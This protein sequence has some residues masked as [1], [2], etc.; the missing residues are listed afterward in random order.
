MRISSIY[1]KSM[2]PRISIGP[3]MTSLVA[4]KTSTQTNARTAIVMFVLLW[5]RIRSWISP[6]RMGHSGWELGSGCCSWSWTDP[7]KGRSPSSSLAS[8][9]AIPVP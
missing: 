3:T 2:R 1:L 5:S 6:L 9:Q 8:L 4:G 7:A